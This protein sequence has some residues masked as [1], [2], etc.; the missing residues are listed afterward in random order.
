VTDAEL[1]TAWRD[2]DQDA[3]NELV[4]R[5]FRS[6]FSFFDGKVVADVDDLVQRTFLAC[7]ERPDSYRGTGSF[8][9]WLLGIARFQ[10][11][12]HLRRQHRGRKAIGLASVT[13]EELGGSPSSLVGDRQEQQLLARALRRIPMEFQLA[14]ELYY[15]EELSTA[16]VAVVLDVAPGTVRSRLTRARD[17]LRGQMAELG[18]SDELTESTIVNLDKW[19]RSLKAKLPPD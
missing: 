16:D 8:K 5:Y 3:G 18:A 1:L 19:A 7:I 17:L 4:E 6:V 13:S 11:L 12:R 14:I 2:G 10:L 15:W 9:A